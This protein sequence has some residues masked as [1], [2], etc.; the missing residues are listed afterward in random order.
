MSETHFGFDSVDETTKAARVRGVF[1]S[2]A[3]K[4]DLM[5]DLMSLGLHR[6]WKAYTVA[7]ANVRPGD[8]V[9]DLA[10]GTGDL[11]RAFAGPHV[12]DGD[13]VRLPGAVQAERHDVIHQVVLRRHR[14]EHAAHPRRLG[15]FVDLVVA[16]V[17]VAHAARS[18]VI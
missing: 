16:E 14:I 8:K 7:V 15:R 18:C 11:A 17:G 6:A 9:L 13:R 5:N 12:R 2:V 3:P 4:Y 10:G 1:D